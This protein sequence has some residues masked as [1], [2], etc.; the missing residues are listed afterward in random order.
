M[1]LQKIVLFLPKLKLAP[2]PHSYVHVTPNTVSRIYPLSVNVKYIEYNKDADSLT[3]K[4]INDSTECIRNDG[5]MIL[6]MEDVY[7]ELTRTIF[8]DSKIVTIE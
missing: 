4:Y 1:N 6:P 5:N 2:R 8:H 7:Q 3:I